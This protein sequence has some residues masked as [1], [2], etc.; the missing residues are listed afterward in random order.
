MITQAC[1]EVKSCYNNSAIF[2][3][4]TLRSF[5]SLEGF[6]VNSRKKK[7]IGLHS[8]LAIND[9]YQRPYSNSKV[10]CQFGGV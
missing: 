7:A 3:V 1:G 9:C 6:Y 10:G 5:Y 2:M 8:A 4:G